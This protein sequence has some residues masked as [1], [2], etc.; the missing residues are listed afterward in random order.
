MSIKSNAIHEEISGEVYTQKEFEAEYGLD[1]GV[2]EDE[3]AGAQVLTA[4]NSYR[5]RNLKRRR[6]ATM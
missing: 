2:A 4:K 6:A 5:R 1:G 3:Y